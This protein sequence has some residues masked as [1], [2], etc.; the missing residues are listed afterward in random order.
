MEIEM[1]DIIVVDPYYTTSRERKVEEIAN[2]IE[3]LD[4][5]LLARQ[6]E[7]MSISNASS[8]LMQ[9]LHSVSNSAGILI[10][11]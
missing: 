10:W 2:K 8:D 4:Q 3:L 6:K 1:S 11:E 7:S 5:I 9:Q